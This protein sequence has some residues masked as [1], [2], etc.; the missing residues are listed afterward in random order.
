[1]KLYRK[2]DLNN[3]GIYLIRNRVNMKV[4]IGKSR[5]IYKRIKWHVTALNKKLKDEN[6]Y[7]INSWHKHGRDNFEYVV[8]HRI[9]RNDEKLEEKLK[10]KELSY[11]L[12]YRSYDRYYGYNLRIDSKTKCI[13]PEETIKRMSESQKKRFADPNYDKSKHSHDYWKKNPKAKK[14]MAKS[15]SESLRKHNF[16]KLS[17]DGSKEI[18]TY[19]SVQ[20]IIK[21]HPDYKWQCIYAVCSGS[22]NSYKG[23]KWKKIPR[24]D[25]EIVRSREKSR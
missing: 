22:K 15:V 23:F 13:L 1:M 10:E 8:L 20:E 5:N 6:R 19:I 24:N 14:R 18:K 9:D 3:A 7:L 11:M 25:E 16:V 12:V 4:Y 21:E 2:R 17:K